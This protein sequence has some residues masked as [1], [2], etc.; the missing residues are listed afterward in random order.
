MPQLLVRNV[1][2]AVVTAL[3]KRAAEH[4]RSVEAEHRA[5]LEAA[6]LSGT[7]DFSAR[8]ANLRAATAGRFTVD[9]AELIRADRDS[10]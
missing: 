3:R 5:I 8:A 2:E 4:H 10:R 6:L 1:D 9:S 7:T